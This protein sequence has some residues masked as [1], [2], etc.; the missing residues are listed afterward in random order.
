MKT[1]LGLRTESRVREYYRQVDESFVF[2]WQ[3]LWI[4]LKGWYMSIMRRKNTV[5]WREIVFEKIDSDSPKMW[6]TSPANGYRQRN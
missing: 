6:I 2:P 1:G 5:K 4:A 3:P